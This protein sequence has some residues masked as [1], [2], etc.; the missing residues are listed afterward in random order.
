M[1][2]GHCPAAQGDD[3]DNLSVEGGGAA[4]H[5]H[6]LASVGRK[7]GGGFKSL[8][9]FCEASKLLQQVAANRR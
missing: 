2:P 7:M 3:L 5:Q 6:A 8:P 1:G 9:R 4:L